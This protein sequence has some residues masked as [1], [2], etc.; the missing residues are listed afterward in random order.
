MI[1]RRIALS[2]FLCYRD[3]QVIDFDDA[4]LWI[5][6]GRNGSGKSTIFDA[7]TF[8]LFGAHRGGKKDA[9]KLINA[10][11]NELQVVFDFD[12]GPETY[13]IRRSLPRNGLTE[14]Q[15]YQCE[16]GNEDE[17]RWPAV[18]DAGSVRA[19]NQWVVENLG[20][21]Y[22]TFTASVLLLQ[23]QAE[24]LLGAQPKN[25]FEIISRI[26]D[27]DR[28]R[29][30]HKRAEER[31]Q[32]SKIQV[33]NYRDQLQSLSKITD[34]LIDEAKASFDQAKSDHVAEDSNYKNLMSLEHLARNWKDLRYR[35]D[36]AQKEHDQAQEL[37]ADA[38][39]IRR[40]WERLR[41]LDHVRPILRHSLE[42]RGELAR[43]QADARRFQEEEKA[44]G[45]K[46][47]L[48]HSLIVEN[49]AHLEALT[50]E[51]KSDEARKQEIQERVVALREPISRNDKAKA[52][53]EQVA[54]LRNELAAFPPDLEAE[55]Q[56]LEDEV[57][58]AQDWCAA[59]PQLTSLNRQRSA[60]ADSTRQLA[61]ADRAI[62]AGQGEIERVGTRLTQCQ[63]VYADSLEEE[64]F[65]Q[66][67]RSQA[68]GDYRRA[69]E[70]LNDFEALQGA[71]TCDRCG[72]PLTE[73]HYESEKA[74]LLSE[75]DES[76]RN[77]DDASQ[78]YEL[79][80]RNLTSVE[81]ALQSWREQR[82]QALTAMEAAKRD[83][84]EAER[85]ARRCRGECDEAYRSLAE[86]FRSLVSET[87]PEDWLTTVF[88][89]TDDL[90]EGRRQI[91]GLDHVRSK[92][93]NGNS[94]LGS[95]DRKKELLEQAVRAL[96]SLEWRV[97]DQAAADEEAR[98]LLEK[99]NL[100]HCLK[101]HE[102]ERT[103]ACET[104][105]RLTELRKG[106]SDSKHE[107]EKNTA[108][109][110]S[111]ILTLNEELARTRSPLP[112]PWQTPFDT[113]GAN[114]IDLLDAEAEA[115]RARGLKARVEALHGVSGV[116]ERAKTE[117]A[118][119]DQRLADL[120]EDA[121]RE[122]SEIESLRIET[123]ERVQ[124]ALDVCNERQQH[125]NDLL[126]TRAQRADLE[127]E[128]LAADQRKEILT[129]LT[130]LLSRRGLQRELIRAAE[131]GIL[132][133]ANPILQEI[134]EGTLELRLLGREEGDD[135]VL[136]L[137][138]IVR[139]DGKSSCHDAIYLSGSQRF[140]VAISLA[141]GIGQFACGS[142]HRSIGSVMIDEGFGCLDRYGLDAIKEELTALK[143]RLRRIILV[144]HQEDL[145][146]AF[147]DG[148]SFE[149]INGTTVAQPF[150]R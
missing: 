26:V 9:P 64:Q 97:E 16:R 128:L 127:S 35:R 23:G 25:R 122:P 4:D 49:K 73:A 95:L 141:L 76:A 11:S 149:V 50:E 108:G 105:E 61:Q 107:M 113:L 13:R 110:Q 123:E 38:D 21:S 34:E 81:T 150:H 102:T 140:R 27:L 129:S 142:L 145:A 54:Q 31:W 22:E 92:W 63:D 143:G 40:D 32:D 29:E 60:L 6:S 101:G 82:Q 133:C 10:Q 148:Y 90:D 136:E 8:A 37:L 130:D 68:M 137:E 91:K 103:L 119:L 89:G 71:S 116:L 85:N 41:E 86:P 24:N 30:L 104:L 124:Q 117:M 43:T 99:D 48:M 125:W 62:Q 126:R 118:D 58:H 74:R 98:L 93:K 28:Y 120:P 14:C 84:D 51:I 44:V 72:Q 33:Q 20:L 114:E 144:S 59:M 67:Q 17:V 45:R 70:Q 131:Q 36:Q 147:N 115:L 39:T 83:R 2:G 65:R 69:V 109:A 55:V 77:R 79:A 96:D 53:R 57:R 66:E 106:Q 88:P 75:R 94:Q 100:T 15:L 112:A 132:D 42:R 47:D 138:A 111:R 12:L 146:N 5:F 52:L 19:V 139:I 78:A 121:R 87:I 134:S 18:P 135:H 80:K 3:E 1:P 7:M 56:R 46:L